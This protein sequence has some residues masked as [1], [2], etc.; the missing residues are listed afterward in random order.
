[1]NKLMLHVSEIHP[2]ACPRLQIIAITVFISYS[3]LGDGRRR[4]P[5]RG[6]WD[7]KPLQ[8]GMERKNEAFARA[9]KSYTSI[10][11]EGEGE[12]KNPLKKKGNGLMAVCFFCLS[13]RISNSDFPHQQTVA[14]EIIP[15]S[16]LS[17]T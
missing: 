13:M 10:S 11:P 4:H 1:M 6:G 8:K 5:A 14:S 15:S 16:T 3:F 9:M 7:A 2:A 17:N 12:K